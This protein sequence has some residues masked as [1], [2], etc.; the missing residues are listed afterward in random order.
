M[1]IDEDE[2]PYERAGKKKVDSL[3]EMAVAGLRSCGWQRQWW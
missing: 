1:T 2:K 3:A